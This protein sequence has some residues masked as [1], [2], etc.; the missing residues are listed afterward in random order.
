MKPGTIIRTFRAR[1]G[2]DLVLR[3]V[4]WND[5][6][7]LLELINALVDERANIIIDE[8]VTRE[9]EIEW[10]SQ[11]LARLEKDE[12]LYLVAEANGKVVG[13]SEL[14]WRTRGYN[15]HVASIGIALRD[16]FRDVGI[17]TEMMRTLEE[18]ARSRSLKVLTLGAYA[19]NE[20]AH[21][22]YWRMGFK[23]V[24]RIP[25]KFFKEGRYI[26]EIVM[27]KILE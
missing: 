3:A 25:M 12:A 19:T 23:E 1:D 10:L 21:H 8:K 11:R 6:D 14:D 5:L 22:V 4:N 24:G 2:R 15:R 18:H 7:D 26:D 27:A 20:R 17:G 13:A 9:E 16:G